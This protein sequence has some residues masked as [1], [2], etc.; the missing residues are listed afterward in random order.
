[1]SDRSN[2]AR[3]VIRK[4]DL[5]ELLGFNGGQVLGV[6]TADYAMAY[7][8]YVEHHSL[9]V[10]I[11]GEK[12]EEREIGIHNVRIASGVNHHGR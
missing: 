3:I 7:V 6:D 5:A 1:M 12:L 4:T 9:P 10:A 8:F 11:P 2:G